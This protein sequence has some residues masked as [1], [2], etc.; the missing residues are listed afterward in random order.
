VHETTHAVIDGIRKYFTEP[1]NLDVAAFH[2]AFADLAALFRHFS[3]SEVLFETIRSTGG[4]L[5]DAFLSTDPRVAPADG[6]RPP[7]TQDEVARRNPLVGLARQFG[8]A[9]GRNDDLRKALGTPA[10]PDDYRTK[11]EPHDRGS[12]LVAAVFD[13]YF[14]VYLKR[15]APLFEVYRAGGGRIDA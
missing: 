11:T 3:H 10:T 8:D 2:E 14:S 9:I 1:T 7:R 4:R 5:S 13:A 6:A 12:I 15:T